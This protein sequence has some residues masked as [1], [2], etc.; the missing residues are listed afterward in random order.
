M[1]ESELG[2]KIPVGI[3]PSVGGVWIKNGMSHFGFALNRFSCPDGFVV[4]Q[5]KGK[6]LF[7]LK[8]S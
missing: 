6:I 4:N 2:K 1:S 5:N 7:T 8:N 3:V